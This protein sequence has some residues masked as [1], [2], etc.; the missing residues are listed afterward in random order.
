MNAITH[1]IFDGVSR[2]PV[3]R[4]AAVLLSKGVAC[5]LPK[6]PPT[7]LHQEAPI[8]FTRNGRLLELLGHNNLTGKRRGRLVVQGL[9][10][11]IPKRWVVRCDCGTYE[12]RTSKAIRND[13]NAVDACV[14]CKQLTQR[15]R[16]N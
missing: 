2:E 7:L 13:S 8:P 6:M 1:H 10:K 16:K 5:V 14:R 11:Y 9:A 4:Q 15:S 3:D 12:V